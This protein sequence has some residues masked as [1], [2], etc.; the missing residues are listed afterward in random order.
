VDDV[1]FQPLPTFSVT[2][3]S[4]NAL[5]M[6]SVIMECSHLVIIHEIK[7]ATSGSV[8]KVLNN[9]KSSESRSPIKEKKTIKRLN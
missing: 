6:Y 8:D 3:T 9:V 2:Y 1:T 5:Y 7:Y 4:Y